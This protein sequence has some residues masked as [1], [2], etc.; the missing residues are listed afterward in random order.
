M[1]E[2]IKNVSPVKKGRGGEQKKSNIFFYIFYKM[3]HMEEGGN[4]VCVSPESNSRTS[5]WKYQEAD[6][7]ILRKSFLSELL[8]SAFKG[9]RRV[10]IDVD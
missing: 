10:V 7:F 8:N 4:W 9:R 2:D 6:G 5:A 3:C 1:I